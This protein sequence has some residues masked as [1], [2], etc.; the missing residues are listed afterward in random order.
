MDPTTWLEHIRQSL[1]HFGYKL[2]PQ[3]EAIATVL[4]ETSSVYLSAEEVYL[5]VKAKNADVGLATVYR[6]LE[7]L[8]EI[9]LIDRVMFED[10]LMRY[11]LMYEKKEQSQYLLLCMQCGVTV[12]L[13]YQEIQ[14]C[15]KEYPFY[16][17]QTSLTIPGLCRECYQHQHKKRD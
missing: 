9:E 1:H 16:I 14:T 6:T 5:Q 12:E 11:R 10:G 13:N 7:I 4:Q 3:R 8:T 17:Q 15:F 2:T